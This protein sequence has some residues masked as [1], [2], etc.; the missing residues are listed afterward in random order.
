MRVLE[1]EE[2]V[3]KLRQAGMRPIVDGDT[4]LIFPGKEHF[5]K[6]ATCGRYTEKMRVPTNR[7]WLNSLSPVELVNWI[8]NTAA[9]MSD[10]ELLIWM[11]EKHE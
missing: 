3:E 9:A 11:E 7:D 1:K 6:C 10:A 2:V 8:K 5:V 4:I